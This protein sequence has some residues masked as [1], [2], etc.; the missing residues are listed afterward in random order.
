MISYQIPLI[1]D[2]KYYCLTKCFCVFV[3][4]VESDQEFHMALQF[5]EAT[6][7]DY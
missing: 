3:H 6:I 2:I 4:L 5:A 1:M 7:Q